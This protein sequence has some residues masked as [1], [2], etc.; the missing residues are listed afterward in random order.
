MK[1]SY[2]FITTLLMVAAVA[3]VV[4][5]CKKETSS[6]LMNNKNESAQSFN[7]REIEDMN[8]YLKDFKQKMQSA[9][10]GEDEALPLDEAAWHLSSLANYD[11]GHANVECDDVRFDT[12]YAQVNVTNGTVLLSDLAAVYQTISSGIEKFYNS[13]ALDNKNFRFINAFVSEDGTVTVPVLTTFSY[14]AKDI[15]DTS[16]YF[17]ND[18]WILLDTCNYYFNA[19]SYPVQTTGTSELQRALNRIVSLQTIQ[20]SNV[21]YTLSSTKRFDYQ[22]Y[23]DPYGSLCYEDSRIFASQG[24]T[25]LDI[26]F[27]ICYLFDSYL[28]LGHQYL[29]SDEYILSWNVEYYHRQQTHVLPS[30]EY[31]SLVVAYGIQHEHTPEPGHGGEL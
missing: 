10:K 28:G 19:T 22:N 17:E 31:H 29:P 7:P 24:T 26:Y 2:L 5:S 9:A 21:Y 15:M 18:V 23:I 27:W 20:G 11:F 6:D 1:K 8:A 14:G 25:N 30:F 13:L 16:W 4:V 3:A 12:L